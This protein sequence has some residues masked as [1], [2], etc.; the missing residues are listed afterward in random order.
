MRYTQ[1]KA[2]RYIPFD[3]TKQLVR[4]SAA[5]LLSCLFFFLERGMRAACHFIKE[6]KMKC[7]GQEG[8]L[9]QIILSLK[10]DL[11]A[12]TMLLTLEI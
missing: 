12:D 1:N 11:N 8:V 5:L 4:I 2:R 6:E 3:A 10:S 7:T 9:I